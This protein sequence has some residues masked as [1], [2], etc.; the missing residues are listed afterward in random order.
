MGGARGRCG[1]GC[2]VERAQVP[3]GVLAVQMSEGKGEQ[4]LELL[5]SI[6]APTKTWMACLALLVQCGNGPCQQPNPA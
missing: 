3:T 6:A 5:A 1:Y 4:L 2:C